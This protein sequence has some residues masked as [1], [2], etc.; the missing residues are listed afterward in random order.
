MKKILE[1]ILSL[2]PKKKCENS[3][4]LYSSLMVILGTFLVFLLV[5]VSISQIGLLFVK[6]R[7]YLTN[8]DILE[9]A[10]SVGSQSYI[11][12]GTLTMT[13]LSGKPSEKIEILVNGEVIDNFN[14]KIK[15]IDIMSQSVIEIKAPKDTPIEVEL[16]N[17]SDTLKTVLNNEKIYV[18][19]IEVLCRVVFK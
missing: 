14:E 4:S 12:K 9:G 10:I 3:D 8:V 11:D 2:L 13:L 18:K 17:I 1:R 5:V 15:T 7:Q 16:T 19:G 6:S